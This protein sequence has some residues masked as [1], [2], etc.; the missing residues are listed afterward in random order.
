MGAVTYP[1]ERVVEFIKR[2]M[3]P[4]QVLFDSQPLATNFNIQ[5]TPTVITLDEEGKEHHRTIGFLSPEEFIPSLMLGVAKCHFDR[6]RFSEAIAMIEE[7]LKDYPKSDAAPEAVYM[8]GVAL[9][10]STHS[11]EPLKEAYKRLQSEYPSSEWAKR[12]QPYR[13]L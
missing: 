9:Y 2:H 8:Q 1:N 4:I 12:A 10:K 7:T 3:V 5:W 13:L 11:A 6:E